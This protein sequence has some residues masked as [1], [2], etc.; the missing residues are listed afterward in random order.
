MGMVA[1]ASQQF[2]GRWAG[3]YDVLSHDTPGLGRLRAKA[4]DALDL[5]PGDTVLDLGCGTGANVPYLERAVGPSG[6]VLGI[7]FTRPVLDRAR[8]RH[9]D[10]HVS[11]VHADVD[12]LPLDEPVDAI[13]A[14]FLAGMLPDPTGTLAAWTDHLAPGGTIGLLD[15][16]LSDVRLA[17][18]LN[19]GVKALV[20]ASAPEKSLDRDRAPWTTVTRRVDL[21]HA[22]IDAPATDVTDQTW[23]LGTVRVTAGTIDGSGPADDSS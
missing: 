18:P 3:L 6:R 20:F 1:D 13:F 7:D 2:Y 19:Q 12:A 21:A 17:W 15:A 22:A 16:S 4:V 23:L 9:G 8:A 11:F 14:T 10:E 5:A